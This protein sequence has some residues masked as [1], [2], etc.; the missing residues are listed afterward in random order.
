MSQFSS[1]LVLLLLLIITCITQF[2]TSIHAEIQSSDSSSSSSSSL[3]SSS[4]DIYHDIEYLRIRLNARRI[5]AQRVGYLSSRYSKLGIIHCTTSYKRSIRLCNTISR[6]R[7]I[8][9]SSSTK[10]R[11]TLARTS[12]LCVQKTRILRR[13]QWTKKTCMQLGSRLSILKQLSIYEQRE[14]YLQMRTKPYAS[15]APMPSNAPMSKNDIYTIQSYT[16]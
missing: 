13:L 1:I 4:S 3:S 14:K 12:C 5:C 7:I 2:S 15:N 8:K 6:L 10:N 11:M 16:N 9:N